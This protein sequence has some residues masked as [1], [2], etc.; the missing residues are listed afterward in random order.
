MRV[1]VCV[2]VCLSKCTFL[3]CAATVYVD[4]ESTR[5]VFFHVWLVK[6][7]IKLC[8]NIRERNSGFVKC[9]YIF[10]IMCSN[11]LSILM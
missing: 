4:S 1:C 7:S 3:R 2:H 9:V 6:M 5:S 11:V 8:T 10:L